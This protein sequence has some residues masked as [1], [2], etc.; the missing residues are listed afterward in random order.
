MASRNPPQVAEI[1]LVGLLRISEV[2]EAWGAFLPGT[3]PVVR[4]VNKSRSGSLQVPPSAWTEAGNQ[5]GV[6]GTAFDYLVGGLWAGR[7]LAPVFARVH[8]VALQMQELQPVA[9]ALE[10][11]LTQELPNVRAGLRTER[12]EDFFRGLGL[13]AQLDAIFRSLVEPPAWVLDAG[14]GLAASGRLRQALKK[15]Y[16]NEMAAE[17]RALFDATCKDLPREGNVLYNPAFGCPPGLEHVGADGD[18]LVGETLWDLKV[19]KLPFTRDQL[20]QLLGYAALDRLHG[21]RRIL[22]VGLYNPRFRHAWSVDVET[23]AQ[24]LGCV[25]L[26][27]F[28]EWFRAEPAANGVAALGL[29]RPRPVAAVRTPQPTM[30]ARVRRRRAAGVP[31]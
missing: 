10:R 3:T 20:W 7:S 11:L 31:L 15:H 13:L 22:K 6:V 4:H 24:H 17:L 18:L 25:S 1:G 12:Q 30:R 16:P 27:R 9:H 21:N 29:T 8:T 5:Y 2:R 26:E 23:F 28:A 19:S 14:E